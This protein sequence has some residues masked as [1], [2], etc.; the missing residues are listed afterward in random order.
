MTG[1]AMGIV[2]TA[3]FLHATWNYLAKCSQNKLAFIWWF[4]LSAL[5]F[6]LPMF[7]YYL[8]RTPI[9]TEGWLFILATGVVHFF[10]FWFLGTAYE[11]GDLS[12]VYPLARGS[13]PLL[14]PFLALILINEDIALSGGAGI[15]LIVLGIYLSH[16]RSF[17]LNSFADP[18]RAVA[19]GG[20]SWALCTGL[21]IAAYSLVDKIGVGLVYPP[22][23]IYFMLLLSWIFLTP[24]VFHQSQGR[25]LREWQVNKATIMAVGVIVLGA[26][27]MIL[28]A[29]TM[30]KV[31]YVVAVREVSI[32]F[33][34]LYGVF[35]LKE[36]HGRQKILGAVM[37]ALGVVLIGLSR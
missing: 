14:V 9:N 3:A 18:F 5:V 21:T 26:Y 30:A 31:S 6:Y 22:V 19:M 7:L 12:L 1:I 10:Y 33:S 24:L 37:I 35:R 17:S 16:L 23:Y 27:M 8:P 29:L 2:L 4:I 36:T 11:K 34:V 28:F 32:V 25:I 20:S 15:A 13:G